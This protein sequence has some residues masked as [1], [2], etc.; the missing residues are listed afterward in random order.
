MATL[1]KLV[2][3][4]KIFN[5]KLNTLFFPR[6][7]RLD[8][9]HRHNG[10]DFLNL[11]S[12]IFFLLKG[13]SDK[14]SFYFCKIIVAKLFPRIRFIRL[15]LDHF[16]PITNLY[17]FCNSK[18]FDPDLTYFV[19]CLNFGNDPLL[20]QFPENIFPLKSWPSF[21]I[22]GG[23]FFI[24]KLSIHLV[25]PISF[26]I[27]ENWEN[28]DFHPASLPREELAPLKAP[29]TSLEVTGL[30][31]LMERLG[32]SKYVAIYARSPGWAQSIGH[33]LRN[34]HIEIFR[35]FVELCNTHDVK[36]V[37]YGGSYQPAW[38]HCSDALIDTTSWPDCGLRDIEIWKNCNAVIGSVSG[39][40]HV[41]NL[42]FRKPTLYLGV[43]PIWELLS[44]FGLTR[45]QALLPDFVW[46][47]ACSTLDQTKFAELVVSPQTNNER[48]LNASM[49]PNPEALLA[50]AK[51]FL[52][53]H[54]IIDD[55]ADHTEQSNISR[56]SLGTFFDA[57]S[58]TVAITQQATNGTLLLHKS[59][60]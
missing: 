33:S 31:R 16:G 41:P 29:N 11:I 18:Q 22:F 51:I 14:L 30:D 57:G 49:P 12:V 44:V 36:V 55:W 7:V 23:G 25:A 9:R 42:C 15:N 34:I 37:R 48:F 10:S 26:K 4:I 8:V 47:L 46:H 2:S 21:L 40:T 58:P 52:S 56:Y 60:S 35:N 59:D 39:A 27:D 54:K 28:F 24:K 13:F 1:Q 45:H 6:F 17:A 50:A 5:R 43:T 20:N 32:G 38:D 19:P 53:H 3:I